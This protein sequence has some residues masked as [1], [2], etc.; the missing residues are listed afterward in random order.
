MIRSLIIGLAAWLGLGLSTATSAEPV[1]RSQVPF[2]PGNVIVHFDGGDVGRNMVTVLK[3][4]RTAPGAL[5]T[6]THRLAAGEDPC[7]MMTARGF[8]PACDPMWTLLKE[9]NPDIKAKRLSVGQPLTVPDLPVYLVSSARTYSTDNP[10][11][12]LAADSLV[13]S[14]AS[15]GIEDESTG[16]ARRLTF[17]AYEIVIPT[18]SP[19]AAAE[20]AKRVRK[21]TKGPAEKNVRYYV[22]SAPRVVKAF[23]WTSD[24]VRSEC[25]P[26]HQPATRRYDD[27]ADV[28]PSLLASLGPLPAAPQPPTVFIVDEPL[29]DS[30]NLAAVLVDG[31]GAAVPE[32]AWQCTWADFVP[33][34][35]HANHMAGIIA[36]RKRGFVGLAPTVRLESVPW[37]VANPDNPGQ[38]LAPGD[39][40]RRFAALLEER[41][42][43][44]H[45]PINVY[46]IASE[47]DPPDTPL[48][49]GRL[50]D[51]GVRDDIPPAAEI[52]GYEPLVIVAAGQA[53]PGD[54]VHKLAIDY[55]ISPQNL[56]DWENVVVVTACDVCARHGATLMSRAYYSPTAVHLAAPGGQ[57]I[58]G[59]ISANNV[60]AAAGTSQ[61]AA[62]VTGVAAAM[63]TRYPTVYTAAKNVKE[64]LQTSAWPILD[65][66]DSN[67]GDSGRVAIGLVDPV[68]AQLDPTKHW[69]KDAAGWR[70]VKLRVAPSAAAFV[71]R[72]GHDLS[73]RS[74]DIR[75]IVR[76]RSAPGVPPLYALLPRG[77]DEGSVERVG[78]L[79]LRGDPPAAAVCGE[80]Q[81][82]EFTDLLIALNGVGAHECGN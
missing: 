78:P 64:R 44:G 30:P 11:E 58:A 40:T 72:S 23:S 61:A 36:S 56:G 79:R 5:P 4:I 26:S 55:P 75:R 53:A 54:I 8:P 41:E 19:A 45:I 77:R 68:L 73:V 24:Q 35:H 12:Q 76:V 38:L 10:T 74:E 3:A 37:L 43:N 67:P 9:L 21:A 13:K 1:L 29:D 46:L 34:Q 66:V 6:T 82:V 57:P 60:G 80:E 50:A 42:R 7:R 70:A 47:F 69:I 63:I 62:Y 22:Y 18:R 39:R 81:P 31:A 20:V 32:E 27:L 14:W 49:N 2:A 51:P 71:D 15:K 52:K 59:W 33:S 28:E 65:G 25:A 17:D 16:V 48:D